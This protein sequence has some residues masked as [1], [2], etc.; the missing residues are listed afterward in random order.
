MRALP[1]VDQE[2]ALDLRL[3]TS[4]DS[5]DLSDVDLDA[6][7]DADSYSEDLGPGLDT[8]E[9]SSASLSSAEES[10]ASWEDA[11][12]SE[13]SGHGAASSGSHSLLYEAETPLGV[14]A[15]PGAPA[16][17]SPSGLSAAAA[18]QQLKAQGL[19]ASSSA[20]GSAG[21]ADR[22]ARAADAH[23]RGAHN[24]HVPASPA[25]TSTRSAHSSSSL[26]SRSMCSS[27]CLPTLRISSSS[28]PTSLHAGSAGTAAA[29]H[30][31][32][33]TRMAAGACWGQ[34]GPAQRRG[35]RLV[36]RAGEQQAILLT[37]LELDAFAGSNGGPAN[38]EAASSGRD[39]EAAASPSS[40]GSDLPGA[41]ADA[42]G[43]AQAAGAPASANGSSFSRSSSE[44]S[45]G[46]WDEPAAGP[47]LEPVAGADPTLGAGSEAGSM[48]Q[49]EPGAGPMAP[50]ELGDVVSAL[51]AQEGSLDEASMDD[52]LLCSVAWSGS[53][54]SLDAS[55][56]EPQQDSAPD[57]A[58]AAGGLL[59]CEAGWEAALLA[60]LL[61]AGASACLQ[62]CMLQV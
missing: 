23:P 11:G 9:A 39:M 46:S 13:D 40:S 30:Y 43:P 36:T 31:R 26:G 4:M 19:E 14:P 33:P 49:S 62:C 37:K 56:D 51:C 32:L 60:V 61:C 28:F 54:T 16:A 35:A 6:S 3:T 42:R 12:F 7:W 59:H 10:D 24:Q 38:A 20:T 1:W 22:A 25:S 44:A 55:S 50:A 58:L 52:A 5:D 15:P 8:E 21:A 17:G 47:K 41:D 57:L 18:G 34:Q 27:G 45:S 2:T 53:G 29:R 48:A